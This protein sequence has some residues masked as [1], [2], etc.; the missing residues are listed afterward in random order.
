MDQ[1]KPPENLEFESH[2]LA[3]AWKKWK[4]ENKLYL[5]LATK[6]EET[7]RK[8]KLFLYL[9]DRFKGPRNLRDFAIRNRG[10]RQKT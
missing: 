4:E 5:Y 9:I 7:E 1:L 2:D 3:Y 6:T 10:E 8:V